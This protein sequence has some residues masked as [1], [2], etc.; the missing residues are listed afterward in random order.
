[1]LTIIY[2]DSS[3]D[4]NHADQAKQIQIKQI[5][6]ERCRSN[7]SCMRDADHAGKSNN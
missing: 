3:N 6:Q 5:I 1:M 2:H 4:E 7:G